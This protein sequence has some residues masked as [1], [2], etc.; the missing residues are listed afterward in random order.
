[1]MTEIIRV[2]AEGAGAATGS[3]KALGIIELDRPRARNAIN[4]SMRAGIAEAFPRYARDP[5]IYAVL[6]ASAVPGV[7]SAGGDLR[8]LAGLVESDLEGAK[9]LLAEKYALVWLQECFSKP[10]VSLI[11]GLVMGN[12]VAL[13]MY[14][15]HRVAGE[16]YE[17]AMP[18]AAVGCHPDD[19]LASVFARMPG[20]V[21]LYLALTGR[22]IGRADAFALGLVTHCIA[23]ARFEEIKAGLADAD[24]VDPLL[25]DRHEHPGDG[26]LSRRRELIE[27]CFSAPTLEEIV[28][29]LDQGARRAGEDGAWCGAVLGDLGRRS[30]TALKVIFRHV[31][32]AE[33]LDLRETLAVDYR[34]ACRLVEGHDFREGVRSV[35]K[36][37]DNNPQWLP[38]RIET[39]D[40]VIV[41]G[42][43]AP[44]PGEELGLPSREEMQAARV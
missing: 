15:T 13:T 16:R 36:D 40:E 31:R 34:L 37:K 28:A 3:R 43:F 12:G 21:G 29:R 39:V 5:N 6:I 22:R 2:A 19:G 35:L 41:D 9:R 25:D 30:P 23:A 32:G 33:G 7:F 27:T 42:F 20:Q 38:D 18:E 14:G 11:D 10:T 17:F 44:M 1:M 8:E 4:A 26:D 24:P